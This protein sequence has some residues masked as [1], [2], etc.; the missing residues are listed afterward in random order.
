MPPGSIAAL[1]ALMLIATASAG[2]VILIESPGCVKCAAAERAIEEILPDA[3]LI[4]LDFTSEE[5]RRLIKEYNV[6]KIPAIILVD[7]AIDYKDYE[8]DDERLREL[9]EEAAEPPTDDEGTAPPLVTSTVTPAS[10]VAVFLAGLLA[11][12]NPCLLGILAFLAT[13]VISSSGQRRDIMKMV[14][15]FC[16]GIFA[17]YLLVGLGMLHAMVGRMIPSF[18]YALS[19]LLAIVGLV[20]IV[21][22][23]RLYARKESL[24]RTD[25]ALAYMERSIASSR[26][27]TYFLA[28]ALFSLVKV[29]CVGAVYIAILDMIATNAY[30]AGAVYLVAYNLG[31]VLPV[32]LLGGMM[33]IGLTPEQ[34]DRFRKDYR[35][36]IRLATGITLLILAPLILLEII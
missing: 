5:G 24:F 12:F 16:L 31:V 13:A 7:R 34:V 32:L 6:K 25:W 9:I 20:H 2:E 23:R 35:A 19:G 10:I 27:S 15:C 17:V 8:G 30:Q 4:K 28:G 3:D 21:D 1:L 36:Q 26:A 33:T 22:A 18:R 11:G 14:V 29:P